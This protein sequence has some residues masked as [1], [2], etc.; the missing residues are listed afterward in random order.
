MAALN[1]PDTP[2]VDDVYT[3]LGKSW[4]FDGEAWVS[5]SSSVATL[6]DI[7]AESPI[8]YSSSSGVIGFDEASLSL[9]GGTA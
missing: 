8:T 3:S 4:V 7:S 6:E 9:D 1:F 5:V 2:E